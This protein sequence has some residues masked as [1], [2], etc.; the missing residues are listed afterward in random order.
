MRPDHDPDPGE[1]HDALDDGVAPTHVH[2]SDPYDDGG[3]GTG[4]HDGD[5]GGGHG[6]DD[7]GSV[8]GGGAHHGEPSIDDLD[9]D[10]H[11]GSPIEGIGYLVD[12]VE[13]ALFHHDGDHDA[14]PGSLHD[15]IHDTGHD[16]AVDGHDLH[17]FF[18]ADP[19]DLD[20]HGGLEGAL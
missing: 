18:D 4:A 17:G 19:A 7:D 3:F 9:Q 16:A 14:T 10:I 2:A 13:D 1:H 8:P 12:V 5:G 6:G 11:H 15:T 20:H